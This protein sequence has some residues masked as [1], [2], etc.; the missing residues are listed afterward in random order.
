MRSIDNSFYKSTQWKK[1]RSAYWSTHPI[2]E[3][4][5]AQGVIT[6]TEIIH[7]KVYLT[8]ENMNNAELAYGFDNLEALCRE[9]HNQEHF[10]NTKAKRWSFDADGSLIIKDETA[11]LA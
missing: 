9:H 10:K 1:C 11:P 5:L 6:P 7:H 8:P 3:R 4:C 2:C